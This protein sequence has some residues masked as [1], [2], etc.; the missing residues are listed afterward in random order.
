MDPPDFPGDLL[1]AGRKKDENFLRE[2]GKRIWT[3]AGEVG[4]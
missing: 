1:I 3:G 2:Y 4:F